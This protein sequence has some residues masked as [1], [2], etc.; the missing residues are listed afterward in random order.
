MTVNPG[1][2]WQSLLAKNERGDEY[3]IRVV[4]PL[5]GLTTLAAFAGVFFTE[6]SFSWELA[7]KSAIRMLVALF[8]GF[9]LSAFLTNELCKRAFDRPDDI[10]LCRR[11]TGYAS[12]VMYALNIALSVLPE[13]DFFYLRFFLLYIIYI[14]WEG[15]QSYMDIHDEL[16][17]GMSARVLFTLA[18]STLIILVPTVV[19]GAL[20]LL[21]PGLR[22]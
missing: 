6:K 15:A 20:F 14:V 18:V 19:K 4:Y 12:M 2:T 1:K 8:G 16:I 10:Q 13:S 9:H 5:I 22:I 3:L 7:L 17:S 21:M 11:F